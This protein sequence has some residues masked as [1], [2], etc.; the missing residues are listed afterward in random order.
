[1]NNSKELTP[2]HLMSFGF[3]VLIAIMVIGVFSEIAYKELKDKYNKLKNEAIQNEFA[4]YNST[5]GVWQWKKSQ[6]PEQD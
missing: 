1:M 3:G 5:T 2:E 4:E 6:T